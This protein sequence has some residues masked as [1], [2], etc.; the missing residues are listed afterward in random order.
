MTLD[1]GAKTV[2]RV[3][4]AIA[5]AWLLI[6]LWP[7]VLVV[8]FA[9]MLAAAL[10]PWV[11]TLERRGLARGTSIALVFG[12][13]FL[14]GAAFAVLTLPP[15]FG[16]LVKV[17]GHLPE[18]Q[19]ELASQLERSSATAPLARSVRGTGPTE[20][21]GA[22]ARALLSNSGNIIEGIA[23][24][25][26]T[27]FLALYVIVDR[28][29]TRG[30]AFALVPRHFHLRLS[31]ILLN[32]ETI[33]GGYVRGQVVT[34]VLMAAF[35]FIVLTVI[36]VPNALTL[37]FFAGVADVLPYVGGI[38]MC[39]PVAV[40]TWPHGI[41]TTLGVVLALLGYQELESRLV[42]PRV[43]GH[44]LRLPSSI[45]LI[46][47]LVG[48]R[49]LGIVGALL[50]L[51]IAAGI[52]MVVQELRFELPGEDGARPSVAARDA[53]AEHAFE[54]RAAGVPAERA[55]AIAVEIAAAQIR[56]E[57]AAERKH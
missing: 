9:L 13:L 46:S 20:L 52:R 53:M 26:T 25:T 16:Q 14:A 27:F 11:H 47:L 36:G 38:L 33:V 40:A 7:I 23:Y 19:A 54:Q 12:T 43:Y 6:R 49:L 10:A 45:V 21:T 51:P 39:A 22:A 42:V 18:A 5:A 32:L 28:D 31:R 56:Q 24:A 2:L 48:G 4:V 41:G 29:R 8:I 3:A 50:A 35:T 37:A 34:S 15:L 57:S 55:A 17:V 44:A 30:A 1:V